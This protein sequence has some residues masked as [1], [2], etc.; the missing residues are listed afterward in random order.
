MVFPILCFPHK[1]FGVH[2]LCG[3]ADVFMLYFLIN[4]E[5]SLVIGWIIFEWLYRIVIQT[6]LLV[7]QVFNK[8]IS[9]CNYLKGSVTKK[10]L[11]KEWGV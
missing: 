3:V 6:P 2:V 10:S 8:H 7:F 11:R 9:T 1:N 5:Y 4:V